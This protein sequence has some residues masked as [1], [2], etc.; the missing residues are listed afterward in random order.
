[1][2]AHRPKKAGR[3]WAVMMIDR[4]IDSPNPHAAGFSRWCR[5]ASKT[6]LEMV[7]INPGPG[8]DT[9]LRG[10][11]TRLG[12]DSR[13]DDRIF[14]LTLVPPFLTEPTLLPT[15]VQDQV[16]DDML[17]LNTSA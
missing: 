16:Q 10:T 13:V 8:I 6:R 14:R 1:M 7:W 2:H 3:L 4:Q 15:S 17:Q 5:R 12:V 11:A 9:L